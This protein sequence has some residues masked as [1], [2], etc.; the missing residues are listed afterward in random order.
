MG[1]IRELLEP[2]LNDIGFVPKN[3][4]FGPAPPLLVVA[5]AGVGV[6]D[7][8]AET[9]KDYGRRGPEVNAAAFTADGTSLMAGTA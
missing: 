2:P 7:V 4:T 6:V 3:L 8:E 9:W 1:P 5:G